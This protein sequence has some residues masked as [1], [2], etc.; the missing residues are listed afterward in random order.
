MLMTLQQL[1]LSAVIIKW[2]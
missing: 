1:D 2:C